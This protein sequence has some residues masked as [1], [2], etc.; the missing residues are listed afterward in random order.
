MSNL[1]A[2]L[3]EDQK[4]AR[5]KKTQET[6]ARNRKRRNEEIEKARAEAIEKQTGL[7][8][9]E[10]ALAEATLRLEEIEARIN[11]ATIRSINAALNGVI[12]ETAAGSHAVLKNSVP[13]KDTTGVYF[14]IKDNEIVYVG[15]SVR[16]YTRISS[17]E[18]TK[19]FDSVSWIRCEV[20]SLDYLESFYIYKFRPK[21]NG[22]HAPITLEKMIDSGAS[23][24]RKALHR[25]E[26][27]IN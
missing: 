6:K 24:L 16:V 27:L 14:L 18:K 9:I 12:A 15:Q 22:E 13:Y 3:T 23:M 21:L 19:D 4:S 8:G 25:Q 26:D 20:E 11:F 2:G 1:W 10:K 7:L 17:H 5:V